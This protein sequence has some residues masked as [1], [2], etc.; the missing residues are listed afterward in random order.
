MALG[1]PAYVTVALPTRSKL[2]Y[3]PVN[4]ANH[5]CWEPVTPLALS[6]IKHVTLTSDESY[7]LPVRS[8]CLQTSHTSS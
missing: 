5:S 2:T 1:V 6:F 8:H 3:R 7:Y 4:L